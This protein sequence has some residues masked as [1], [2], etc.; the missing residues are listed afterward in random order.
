MKYIQCPQRYEK[1]EGEKSLFIAGGIS[2]CRIW[3]DDLVHFLKEEELVVLNPRRKNFDI[4]Q[5]D[6]N[7]EQIKWEFEH[8]KIADAVSFWFPKETLCP[9]TLY[10]LGKISM[11][12]KK[13][14]IGVDPDYKRKEDLEIQTS[15]VRPDVQIVYSLN[16]LSS[17]IK[18]WGKNAS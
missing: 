16:D 6:I 7:Q 11:T 9:I 2:G 18:S 10:E 15:L 13:L 5:K 3:Q 12:E 4:N 14:F 8:L 1:S 17:Q